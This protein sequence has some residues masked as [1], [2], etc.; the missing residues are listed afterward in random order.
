MG[1]ICRVKQKKK[2]FQKR[3]GFFRGEKT[4]C[5]WCIN[6]GIGLSTVNRESKNDNL[7]IHDQSGSTTATQ[8]LLQVM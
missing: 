7:N 2:D 8:R 5:T 4:T 3:K 1:K 6:T